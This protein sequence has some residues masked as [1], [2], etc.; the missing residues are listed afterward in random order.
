MD[1]SPPNPVS[2][3]ATADSPI[4]RSPG[5]TGGGRAARFRKVLRREDGAAAFSRLMATMNVFW[6]TRI[7]AT[8]S[9]AGQLGRLVHWAATA[10]VLYIG[11]GG[12]LGASATAA[13][14]RLFG[15]W[16][17]APMAMIYLI[18]RGVRFIL[19]GE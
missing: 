7:E 19:S 18:G 13:P 8:P 11:A 9:R 12:L 5:E 17:L 1:V 3:A 4:R 16:I 14:D 2:P 6:P 15:L 10:I